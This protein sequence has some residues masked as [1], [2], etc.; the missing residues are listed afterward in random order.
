MGADAKLGRQ[1]ENNA[2]KLKKVVLG[3]D[4]GVIAGLHVALAGMRKGGVRFAVL[5]SERVPPPPP[6]HCSS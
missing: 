1:L 6:P 2:G 4:R 3:N 5:V